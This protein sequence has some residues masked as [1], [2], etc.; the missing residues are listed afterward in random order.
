MVKPRKKIGLKHGA[1]DLWSECGGVERL[2]ERF[3]KSEI[4]LEKRIPWNSIIW[5]E[6]A[7][8]VF[9]SD[10]LKYR[11]WLS[12]VWHSNRKNVRSTVFT[13]LQIRSSV[14]AACSGHIQSALT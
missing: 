1:P 2:V 3:L 9:G 4:N 14:I 6:V 8:K 12:V 7:Q 5:S 13:R 10:T 11:K